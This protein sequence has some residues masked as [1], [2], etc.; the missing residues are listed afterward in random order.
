MTVMSDDEFARVMQEEDAFHRAVHDAFY[1]GKAVE[2]EPGTYT[3]PCPRCGNQMTIY[4]RGPRRREG[5]TEPWIQYE[6]CGSG[7]AS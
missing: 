2:V 5:E 6:H 7:I 1:A 3:L 4:K